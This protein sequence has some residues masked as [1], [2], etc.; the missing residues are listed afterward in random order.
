M[1]KVTETITSTR[2]TAYTYDVTSRLSTSKVDVESTMWYYRFDGNG[3]LIGMTP[4]GSSPANGAI[5]YTY[6]AANDLNKIETHN[7]S[8]YITL[9]QMNY[10]GLGNR[11]RLIAW[12]SGIPLT[13]TYATRIAGQ[14][15]ILQASSGSNTTTYLY[16]LT[17][18]GE[19]G[20]QAVYYLVDGAG[21]VRQLTDLNGA[22]VLT[23]WYEPLGQILL[24]R[25]SGDATYGYLG[26]QVDRI[27]GLLYIN[28]AYYDPVTG[29]FL[30]PNG[31]GQNPYVPVAGLSLA[32]FIVLALLWRKKRGQIWTGWL[33]VAMMMSVGLGI[34]A[35]TSPNPIGPTPHPTPSRTSAPIMP[36]R[37]PT[38]RA[39]SVP[40]PT[41]TS[42][43][44]PTI[45][46]C[47]TP[48][49]T[50]VWL[51][52][53]FMIT[54]YTFALESDPR[55]ANDSKVPA[56]GLP[57]DKLY[58]D[59]FLFGSRGIL[60]QGTGLAEDG[61]Y[62]TI[63]WYTEGVGGVHGPNARDTYFTYGIGGKGGTPVAWQT[64]ATG[65]TRLPDGTKIQIE[66][67]PDKVFTIN[68]TGEA[69]GANH[70]DVFVGPLTI[71]EADQIGTL[72]S[73]VAIVP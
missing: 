3:N 40:S 71:Q 1:T 45:P 43:P 50:P 44:L 37:T 18:L 12:A 35:C 51:D 16:G 8:S 13:T 20:S 9:A 56:N 67:Y 29:R 24:Q 27:T 14:V 69:V 39:S 34:A 52:G 63:D 28:G 21:S 70:I 33:V 46:Q 32:P 54:H 25:G 5:R 64:A 58:R 47:P 41:P 68:D 72:T 62:I 30:T 57:P 60:Q 31:S 10:D 73:R 48:N 11:T 26:A 22:V 2:V 55:Y 4:N 19:F 6:D 49:A 23:R 38:P 59:G 36:S 61:D 53:D 42:T 15:Q 66:A 7:G 17:A 65:D